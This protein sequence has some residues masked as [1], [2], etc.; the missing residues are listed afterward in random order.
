MK[1]KIYTTEQDKTMKALEE[2][3]KEYE[4]EFKKQDGKSIMGF[5]ISLT[6]IPP[7]T[8]KDQEG[9]LLIIPMPL[10]NW[11]L[12]LINKK[13]WADFLKGYLTK[14]NISFKDVK[15]IGE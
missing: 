11:A 6:P 5:K 3:K 10:P 13:A 4:D 2:F 8:F 9:V 14:R 1:F 7:L 15:Y 12:K